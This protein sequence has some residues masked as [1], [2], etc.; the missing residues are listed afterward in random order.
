MRTV[1]GSGRARHNGPTQGYGGGVA[2]VGR[3]YGDETTETLDAY[4]YAFGWVYFPISG[5]FGRWLASLL[6]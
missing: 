5:C 3:G 1:R 2:F 6:K 4:A